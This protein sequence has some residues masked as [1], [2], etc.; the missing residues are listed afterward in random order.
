[1]FASWQQR[2]LGLDYMKLITEESKA[3]A[4]LRT[5]EGDYCLG[6]HFE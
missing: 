4:K 1:M 5:A 6:Q 3:A 2:T